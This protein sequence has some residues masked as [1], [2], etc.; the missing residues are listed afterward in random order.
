VAGPFTRYGDV[1]ALLQAADD[2]YVV[3]SPGDEITLRFDAGPAPPLPPGWTR[4][5]LL[6]S[7]GW[8]KDADLNT[9]TG[10]RTTPLPF[11]AMS[12]YP[13][14][15]EERFPQPDFVREWLTRR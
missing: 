4:D 5:F 3:M 11:H 14:G 9:A 6:Y 8:M 10:E 12:K 15:P 13:Y 1:V 7:D 2:R